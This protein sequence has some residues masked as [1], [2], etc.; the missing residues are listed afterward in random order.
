MVRKES[1]KDQFSL[2]GVNN[3]SE[4]VIDKCKFV[5]IRQFKRL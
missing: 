1:L 5:I 3:V 4:E 2:F